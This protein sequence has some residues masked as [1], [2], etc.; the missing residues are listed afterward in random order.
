MFNFVV[1]SIAYNVVEWGNQDS[2]GFFPPKQ[3]TAGCCQALC[4]KMSL[5]RKDTA[6]VSE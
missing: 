1:C 3:D 2:K 4:P 6:L 5:L